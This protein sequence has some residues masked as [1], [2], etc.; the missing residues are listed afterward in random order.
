MSRSCETYLDIETTIGEQQII[1]VVGFWSS[2]AGLVQLVGEDVTL[3]RLRRELPKSGRLYTFNG[4]SFDLHRI[5][6][7]LH[8]DLRA[9]LE[10]WDIYQICRRT[11]LGRL[12]G[13]QKQI[14]SRIGFSRKVSLANPWETTNLW[15]RYEQQ[16]D[17]SAL[18][19]LLRYNAEDLFGLRAIKRYLQRRSLLL[20]S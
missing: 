12:S 2:S 7:H 17:Q 20:A 9:Y 19:K 1:T 18:G 16:G 15:R 5:G 13:T 14:E 11:K 6:K 4:N 10:S 3:R 8:L